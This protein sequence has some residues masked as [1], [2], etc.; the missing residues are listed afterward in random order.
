VLK[1]DRK[2]GRLEETGSVI[3]VPAPVCIR[4]LAIGSDK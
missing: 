1:I 3:Q 2:T 4:M